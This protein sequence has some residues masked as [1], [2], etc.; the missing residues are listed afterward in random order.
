MVQATIT[1]NFAANTPVTI[2]RSPSAESGSWSNEVDAYAD[3]GNDADSLNDNNEQS[4]FSGYGFTIPSGATSYLG[5]C[6]I[7]CVGEQWQMIHDER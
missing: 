6:K 3:G 5:A 1:A 2:T 7:R 4:T